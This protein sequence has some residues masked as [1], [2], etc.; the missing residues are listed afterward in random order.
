MPL[1][2]QQRREDPAR[3]VAKPLEGRVRVLAEPIEELLGRWRIAFDQCRRRL[4]ALPD[5]DEPALGALADV[6]L[7]SPP[8]GV[9]GRHETLARH[10][11]LLGLFGQLL[12]PQRQL[13]GE[14]DVVE[15]QPRLTRKIV[16]QVLLARRERFARR[17]EHCD[18][19]DGR[20]LVRD[21]DRL[22]RSDMAVRPWRPHDVA[23]AA[24]Q[25]Y[26]HPRVR[27]TDPERSGLC[28]LGQDTV[29]RQG[30]GDPFGE[31]GHHLVGVGA[32]P[33]DQ[34]VR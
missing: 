5:V 23:V 11:E 24:R 13:V 33:V 22:G 1:V 18:L 6:A 15:C 7:E 27:G 20:S 8:L 31:A 26:A 14:A 17:F 28:H 2:G 30:A 19:A 34:A 21:G 12:Q 25:E 32:P 3:Q 29:D 10:L 9:T 4:D 16:E